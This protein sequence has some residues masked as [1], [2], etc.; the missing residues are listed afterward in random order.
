[1]LFIAH[2]RSCYPKRLHD[3][4]LESSHALLPLAHH[5][6][7]VAANCLLRAGRTVWDL[8]GS[9]N[10]PNRN[11][12]RQSHSLD[13]VRQDLSQLRKSPYILQHSRKILT[14]IYPRQT[15]G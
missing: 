6:P 4:P 9:D 14:T 12:M 15:A 3:R 13:P 10:G 2:V 7:A 11:K 8:D 1:M 5:A